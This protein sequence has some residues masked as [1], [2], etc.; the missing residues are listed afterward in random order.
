MKLCLEQLM[1]NSSHQN[2][3]YSNTKKEIFYLELT[4]HCHKDDHYQLLISAE[5]RLINLPWQAQ[6]QPLKTPMSK[7]S[8]ITQIKITNQ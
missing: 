5:L 8:I 6:R 2:K 7:Q 4:I 1:V 3:D